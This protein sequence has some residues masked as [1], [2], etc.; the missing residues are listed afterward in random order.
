MSGVA[1][2]RALIRELRPSWEDQCR[3]AELRARPF[4]R[5]REE[6]LEL[7]QLEAREKPWIDL[8]F[9]EGLRWM[10]RE[11]K[12]RPIR[13]LTAAEEVQFDRDH[14]IRHAR[15][16][17]GPTLALWWNALLDSRW[18]DWQSPGLFMSK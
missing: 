8:R 1:R 13:R 9:Q 2:R 4:N 3:R 5:T 6:H 7:R 18:Y 17:I 14:Q 10:R 11:K 15:D 16:Y 12:R